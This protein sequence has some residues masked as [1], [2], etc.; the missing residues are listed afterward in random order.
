MLN[1]KEGYDIVKDNDGKTTGKFKATIERSSKTKRL[2]HES[3]SITNSLGLA[4]K[5]REVRKE[6]GT[7]WYANRQ[8]SACRLN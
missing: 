5:Q 3:I 7:K 2:H 4:Q 6:E 1:N 8:Q